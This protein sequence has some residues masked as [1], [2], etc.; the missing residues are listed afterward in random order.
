MTT[1]CGLDYF[2]L[3]DLLASHIHM[4]ASD[5]VLIV[6]AY[7]EYESKWPSLWSVFV[8]GLHRLRV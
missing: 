5:E 7:T 6:T 1:F 2:V 4:F 8:D 3:G